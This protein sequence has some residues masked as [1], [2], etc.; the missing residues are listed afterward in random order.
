MLDARVPLL[1]EHGDDPAVLE[2][3]RAGV[4][5]LANDPEGSHRGFL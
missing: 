1:L 3:R 2:K 4:V 5:R